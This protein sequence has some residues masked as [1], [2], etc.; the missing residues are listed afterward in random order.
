MDHGS[1][2]VAIGAS[3]GAPAG[4]VRV[5]FLT[6]DLEVY[7]EKYWPKGKASDPKIGDYKDEANRVYHKLTGFAD[8]D[9][10]TVDISSF[11]PTE[12]TTLFVQFEDIPMFKLTLRYD[13]D[14]IDGEV[15]NSP[16][17]SDGTYIAYR[18]EDCRGYL[19]EGSEHYSLFVPFARWFSFD[20]WYIDE[21]LTEKWGGIVDGNTM[22][23]AG[24]KPQMFKEYDHQVVAKVG[25]PG[26]DEPILVDITSD[27]Y[28]NAVYVYYLG[29]ADN[30]LLGSYYEV[31][32][33][34]GSSISQSTCE[35]VT[36]QVSVYVEN[37]LG[38][39]QYNSVTNTHSES[40]STTKTVST[41]STGGGSQ[42][43]K[44]LGTVGNG[45]S[46]AG[47]AFKCLSF[48]A[49]KVGP[50][51]SLVPGLNVAGTVLG[52]AGAA[53]SIIGKIAGDKPQGS[54]TTTDPETQTTTDSVAKTV[55][56]WNDVLST[57]GMNELN[58][59]TYSETDT[60]T[61][62]FRFA[63]I[64]YYCVNG[65]LGGVDYYQLEYYDKGWNYIGSAMTYTAF[66]DPDNE[67]HGDRLVSSK[68]LKGF[69]RNLFD[70]I[71]ISSDKVL[72]DLDEMLGDDGSA[73]SPLVISSR[74][75]YDLLHSFFPQAA[76]RL[77]IDGSTTSIGA[78]AYEDCASLVSVSI[79]DSVTSIG[80]YAFYECIS[81][82]SVSIPPSVTSIG[83]G[84]FSGCSSLVS[85][86]IPP[87]VTSI[88]DSAFYFCESLV[89]VSIPSSVTSIGEDAFGWCAS[90][91]SLYIP[92]KVTDISSSTFEEIG[93]YHGSVW[94]STPLKDHFYMG[95]GHG[96]LYLQDSVLSFS[97]YG[98]E[99]TLEGF[100]AGY[101]GPKVALSIPDSYCGYPVT[102]IGGSAFSGCSSLVSV[103][104][105]DS[106][107]SIGD[108]AFDGCSSLVS[109][110]IPDSVTYI[111]YA[112]FDG[113]FS[114]VSVSIPDSVTYIEDCAFEGCS[115]LVSVSIPDSVT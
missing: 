62:N 29:R 110:S 19:S 18:G 41:T 64:G 63:P 103:S 70:L 51:M 20:G 109:V 12:D 22:L 66:S 73:E 7:A 87:S 31:Y 11:K 104:I 72:A 101:T 86:S 76:F 65:V 9:W 54:T 24:Y 91:A 100:S 53:S 95:Y 107:T 26:F 90:L 97:V 48:V 2:E 77:E 32:N 60:L 80:N 10:N 69:Y 4:T 42:A 33:T 46:F 27:E 6:S 8:L 112:A 92:D 83:R 111:G 82:A 74:A 106:V 50:L 21:G 115:S 113:C 75:E 34:G 49:K 85:V 89:S 78:F 23:F 102:S 25:D 37:T 43:G 57:T 98:G 3:S 96:D 45:L 61:Q 105:P 17:K 79:P 1:G 114:L 28:G 81:L 16:Y 59:Y 5:T 13:S 47:G 38:E 30:V 94:H 15:L 35:A 84:A 99:A 52:V 14:M 55:A 56:S 71:E 36:N 93:F 40:K 58:G 108:Y 68:T 88:R 44:T 67:A 39:H